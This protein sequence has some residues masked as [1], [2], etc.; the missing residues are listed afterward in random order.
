MRR[1]FFTILQFGNNDYIFVTFIAIL[2]FIDIIKRK[3]SYKSKWRSYERAG[4]RID[5]GKVYQL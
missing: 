4:Y 1:A 3:V 2:K 5:E